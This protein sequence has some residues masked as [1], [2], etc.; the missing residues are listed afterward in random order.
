MAAGRMLED[1]IAAMNN[2]A[3]GVYTT[4]AALKLAQ[5]LGVEL[6]I[7]WATYRVLHEGLDPREAVIGLMGRPP[8]PEW[9]GLLA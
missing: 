5:G 3:E 1:I 4:S 9:E 6:P 2:V 8:R 7:A